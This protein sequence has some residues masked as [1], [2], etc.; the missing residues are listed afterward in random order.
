MNRKQITIRIIALALVMFVITGVLS[1]R[2][3]YLQLVNG[4]DYIASAQSQT[5]VRPSRPVRSIT[6][7][8]RS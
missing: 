7:P 5:S 1:L 6:F 8:L 2:L 3:V 4:E